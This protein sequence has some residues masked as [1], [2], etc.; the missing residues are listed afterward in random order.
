MGHVAYQV[1]DNFEKVLGKYTGAPYV[2]TVDS[3]SSAV[4]LCLK[5][6][7]ATGMEI[8]IPSRTFMSIPAYIVHSGNRVKFDKNHPAIKGKKLVGKYQLS[9]LPIWDSALSF[10][11]NMYIPGQFMCLSFSGAIKHL[12]LSKGGAI[13]TDNQGAYEWFKMARYMGRHELPHTDDVF[14]MAG[15]NFYLLPELAARG[16]VLMMGMEENEDLEVEYQDLSDYEIYTNPGVS[17]G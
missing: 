15:W 11:Q 1:V 9:P 13:L 17:D 5:F 12:K 8:T 2:A 4:F 10:T 6:L 16:L 14:E 3:C 7:R